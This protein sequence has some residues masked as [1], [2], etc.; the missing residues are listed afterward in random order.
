[1]LAIIKDSRRVDNTFFDLTFV[2]GL[3]TELDISDFRVGKDLAHF[4]LIFS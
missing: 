2:S 3:Y 1:M 4:H